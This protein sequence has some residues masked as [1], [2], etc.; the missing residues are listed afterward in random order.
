[1][2]SKSTDKFSPRLPNIQFFMFMGA[3][4]A[5]AHRLVNVTMNIEDYNVE[6][7]IIKHVA[8]KKD[9]LVTCLEKYYVNN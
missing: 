9:I 7:N 4:N 1:M 2:F 5:L 6:V 3:F 8:K